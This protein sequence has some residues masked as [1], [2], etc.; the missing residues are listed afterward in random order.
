MR[1][2]RSTVA[3]APEIA[4]RPDGVDVYLFPAVIGGGRGDVEEVLTVARRLADEGAR[5]YLYRARGRPL[6]RGVDAPYAWPRVTRVRN[7]ARRTSRALTL[8]PHFGTTAEGPRPGPLGAAGPWSVERD[9]IERAY[10][11]SNVLH[12]SIEEFARARPIGWLAEERWREGGRSLRWIA[13][14]RG[15]AAARADTIEFARL[16]A[17]FRDFAR[18]DLLALFPGFA[19]SRSFA[20]SFPASVQCGPIAPWPT[21]PPFAARRARALEVLWYASPASSERIASEVVDGLA[22]TGRTV[23]LILRT[24]REVE[25]A[26]TQRVSVVRPPPILPGAWQALWGRESLVIT[27]GSRSLLEAVARGIPFLYFNGLT[28]RGRA[29]RRH[30]PEK[31]DGLVA[32]LAQERLDDRVLRDLK[33]FGAG[34]RVAEIVARAATDPAW[35][36]RFRPRVPGAR[37][38]AGFG[39]AGA[40][41]VEVV[42]RWSDP[43][44]SRAALLAELRRAS[45]ARTGLSKV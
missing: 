42:R 40:L 24:S 4:R 15:S 20:R 11:R 13:D 12:V 18:P 9:A 19:P 41:V 33:D 16:Y 43:T 32:W 7:P 22:A 44:R 28:G 23:R 30:R 1:S 29:R 10:G 38:P 45:R 5:L 2:T 26:P 14:R 6:P 25:V 3:R 37:Y 35:R 39:E 27:T 31:L 17:R 36:S 8:A 21:P 34:R